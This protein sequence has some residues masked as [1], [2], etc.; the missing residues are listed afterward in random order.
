VPL[1]PEYE[2]ASI[3]ETDPLTFLHGAAAYWR[4][5]ALRARRPQELVSADGVVDLLAVIL[6]SL[7]GKVP[8]ELPESAGDTINMLTTSI[9]QV[10][11]DREVEPPKVLSAIEIVTHVEALM[12]LIRTAPGRLPV[13]VQEAMT[14]LEQL[15]PRF[16]N[17][18]PDLIEDVRAFGERY[19]LPLSNTPHLLAPEDWEYRENFLRE[20]LA[21]TVK[22]YYS[23]D[24]AEVADGL[25]DLIYVAI[26]TLQLMG[27]PI[28]AGWRE[29]QR[30]NMSKHRVSRK[31]DSKRGHTWD[32]VK[33]PGW[34][35]P[36]WKMV[37]GS[38]TIAA[39]FPEVKEDSV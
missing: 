35:P 37:L 17:P 2:N 18:N 20:E 1:N 32:I 34:E 15:M 24:L 25:I 22:A 12:A 39:R 16:V 13:K 23:N 29:V 5:Q 3:H 27:I 19:G 28:A 36:D 38:A 33:P 30:A 26:G 6:E 14:F 9:A 21:E 4:E 31:E 8:E 10:V 11:Y 7:G